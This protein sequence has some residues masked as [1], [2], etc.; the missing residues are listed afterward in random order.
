MYIDSHAHLFKED[1]G[2]ELDEVI[3]R[4]RDAGVERI[5]VPGTNVET[6]R[7]A[8]EL[9]E[10]Y[11]FVYACVGIHPHESAKRTDSSLKTIGELAG[12][13]RVVAI[14]EIGLDYHYDFSPR[15]MQLAVFEQQI[16]IAADRKLPVVVHTRESLSD[17]LQVVS[18]AVQ[19]RPT[20]RTSQNEPGAPDHAWRGVFHCFTGSPAE[21]AAL[22]E[23]G[24]VVSFPGIV[25]F[26][27]STA[28]E[29]IRHVG[30]DRILLETDSPYLA[31]VPLRGTRNEPANIVHVG[32][33]IAEILA[34]SES[35]VARQ[36]SANAVRLF[37]L[38]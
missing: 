29:T 23:L 31:P 2:A 15:D 38:K 36:T 12:S 28:A 14:G 5:I 25:T 13:R 21:A 16:A 22:L 7:E 26:K 30:C 3:A 33:K 4:A 1:Y 35:E 18:R 24:F 9:S 32:R 37:A 27:S 10:R 6:S 8:V 19:T 34:I 11:D 17:T 20:W